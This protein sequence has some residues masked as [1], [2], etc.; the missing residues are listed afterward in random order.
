MEDIITDRRIVT[1]QLV[2][3]HERVCREIHSQSARSDGILSLGITATAAAIGIAAANDIG[4]VFMLVPLFVL[5]IYIYA[6]HNLIEV[7]VSDGRRAFLERQLNAVF[8]Q[9]I[10]VSEL[11]T[12]EVLSASPR[13]LFV[14]RRWPAFGAYALWVLFPSYGAVAIGVSISQ[15]RSDFGHWTLLGCLVLYLLLAI[16]LGLT[17]IGVFQARPLTLTVL[18]RSH[19]PQ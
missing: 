2:R 14:R 16:A 5:G 12:S 6:A 10:F 4:E 13:D 3:E 7:R 1:E 19:V 17:A 8:S 9:E 11:L 15:I 18:R